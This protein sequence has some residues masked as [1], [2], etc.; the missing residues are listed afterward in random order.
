M[1]VLIEEKKDV[2]VRKFNKTFLLFW[3]MMFSVLSSRL[4]EKRLTEL[5]KCVSI[6]IYPLE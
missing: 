1:A 4:D 3:E 6:Y 2:F 5:L